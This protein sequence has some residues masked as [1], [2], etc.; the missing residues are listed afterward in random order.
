MNPWIYIL[1]FAAA[2]FA[3]VL[4]LSLLFG[5]FITAVGGKFAEKTLDKYEKK[6]EALL[7]GTDCGDCGQESCAM[8]AAMI[9]RKEVS[10]DICPHV[11]EEETAKF[12]EI[13]DELQKIMTDPTPP[14]RRERRGFWNRKFGGGKK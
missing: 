14:K 4:L 10:D 11:S 3:G 7:P 2:I 13:R 1:L 5:V 12:G 6:T 8:C 9:L